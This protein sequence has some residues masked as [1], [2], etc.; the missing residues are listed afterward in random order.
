MEI[1]FL[2]A[3]NA[4]APADLGWSSF[5]VDRRV[6]FEAPPAALQE[7]NRLGVDVLGIETVVLSHFHG[8]HFG[9]LPFLLLDYTIRRVR[10]RE[11]T[12]IGP[13]GVGERV[14]AL[15]AALRSGVER[16]PGAPFRRRYVEVSDGSAHEIADGTLVARRVVHAPDLD[17]F[18]FRYT[19][20]GRTIGYSGDSTL[21]PA[22]AELARG[23]QAFICECSHRTEENPTHFNLRLLAELRAQIDPR[24]SLIVTHREPDLDL[25]GIP[26]AVA[27]A[28]G[29][30]YSV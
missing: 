7:L 14:E 21:C 1:M 20:G 24:T 15:T 29:A 28:A 13:P 5:L 18:G 25:G 26:N 23:T 17:S 8:D 30:T 2:G 4:F 12:I 10:S 9:G 19:S 6:L 22:L 3:G 16:Q 27:A 11:L